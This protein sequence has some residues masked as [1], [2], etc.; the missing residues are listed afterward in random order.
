MRWVKGSVM[1]AF[2]FLRAWDRLDYLQSR[3][4]EW[5]DVDGMSP[6]DWI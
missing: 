3:C 4:D 6:L 2:E 5:H 1:H